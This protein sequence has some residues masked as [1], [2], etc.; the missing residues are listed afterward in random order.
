MFIKDLQPR[1]T[2]VDVEGE[3]LELSD[4]REFSKFG[5][6]GKVATALMKDGTG[7]IKLSL[8]NEQIEKVK[9]GD[10]VKVTKGYVGEFQGELQLTTGKFGTLEV[11]RPDSAEQP[12]AEAAGPRP[13]AKGAPQEYGNLSDLGDEEYDEADKESAANLDVEEENFS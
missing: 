12:K 7:R 6:Q 3:V 5:R 10:K 4:V 1:Q 9:V 11:T 2:D 13:D 8:W